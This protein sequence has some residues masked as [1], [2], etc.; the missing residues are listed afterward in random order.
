MSGVPRQSSAL[1]VWLMAICALAL[2]YLTGCV[3]PRIVT[4][5]QVVEVEIERIVPVD[6]ALT[7]AQ[8][9]PD[10]PLVTWLDALVL[11]IEYRHRFESCEV[12][13]DAIRGLT[14]GVD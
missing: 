6:P 8:S 3:T 9:H 13:M 10:R 14:D 1:S 2:L 12:R 11:M 4:E 5:R 7:R